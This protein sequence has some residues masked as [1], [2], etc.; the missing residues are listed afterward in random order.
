MNTEKHISALLYRYQCVIVPNFGAFLTEIKSSY[1]DEEIKTFFPPQKQISFNVNIKNNDGLLAN[2]LVQEEGISY[3]EA[4]EAIQT[5]VDNWK[6][7]LN[8][9]AYLQLMGIGSF[10]ANKE[11]S[12]VFTPITVNNFLSTSFGLSSVVASTVS[13][14][15]IIPLQE[16]VAI[17]ATKP[18]KSKYAFVKYAAV[19]TLFVSISSVLVNNAYDAYISDQTLAVEGNVQSQIQNRIQEAT[20]VIEPK[21]PALTLTTRTEKEE[22]IV[23]PYHIVASA[24]KSTENASKAVGQLKAK[25]FEEASFLGKTRHGMY[26]VLYGS[27]QTAEEAR[28]ELNKIHRTVNKDAWILVQ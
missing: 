20:F 16:T 4:V 25:G 7:E 26:P 1:Y 6:A 9:Y 2:H 13:R 27:Y 3:A 23:R 22:V 11:G 19:L 10:K 5:T 21:I 17:E 14:T 24:F 12:L 8:A 18:K 15:P 28:I